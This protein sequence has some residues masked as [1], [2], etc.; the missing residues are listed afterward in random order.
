MKGNATNS[1]WY[2]VGVYAITFFCIFL[3]IK[4]I[5]NVET[6][7]RLLALQLTGAY[8]YQKVEFSTSGTLFFRNPIG[9][10]LFNQG[11]DRDEWINHPNLGAY[12][13]FAILHIGYTILIA[14]KGFFNGLDICYDSIVIINTESNRLI[15]MLLNYSLIFIGGVKVIYSII[16]NHVKKYVLLLCL[17]V[18]VLPYCL[19][20]VEVRF[21]MPLLVSFYA[22]ACFGTLKRSYMNIKMLGVA[23]LLFL[24]LCIFLHLDTW[25]NLIR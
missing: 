25:S 22:I 7:K 20:M 17:L 13:K 21:F 2:L 8:Q 3:I 12:F 10:Y 4:N 1:R 15:F 6:S 9:E 23:Y 11:L 14:M 24:G 19:G 16:R 5:L 18:N